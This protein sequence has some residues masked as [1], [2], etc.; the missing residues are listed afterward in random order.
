MVQEVTYVTCSEC[1]QRMT[2]EVKTGFY[3]GRIQYRFAQCEHCGY[4][5]IIWAEDEE[6]L[7][8]RAKQR[9]NKRKDPNLAKRIM[10]L[11]NLLIKEISDHDL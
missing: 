8:L 10:N 3:K 5:A 4:R 6:I 9:L 11:T 1:Q 2:F 7:R